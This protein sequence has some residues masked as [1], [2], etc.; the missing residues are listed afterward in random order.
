MILSRTVSEINGD[1]SR[2]L[3]IFPTPHV[4]DVPAEGVSLRIGL[5][6][7]VGSQK[8]RVMGLPGRTRSLTI[9]L[10]M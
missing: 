2:K 6:A 1:F 3:P 5:G 8:T 9:S 10:A 7:G 4:F